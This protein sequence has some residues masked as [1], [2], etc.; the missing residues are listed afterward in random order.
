MKICIIS[1]GLLT[2]SPFGYKGVERI[3][4]QMANWLG[5]RHYDVTLVA[6]KGSLEGNF[7]LI[8]TVPEGYNVPGLIDK[9][10]LHIQEAVKKLQNEKF[11]LLINHQ[12]RFF[13]ENLWI[14]SD[15]YHWHVHGWL[16]N[17][18]PTTKLKI[19]AR[20]KAH[21]ELLKQ[22]FKIWEIDYCYNFIE[23]NNYPLVR[24]K[25][26]Y[27]LFFSRICRE[28]GAHNFLEIA[29]KFPDYKFVIAG[30]DDLEKG[31]DANYL[32]YILKL[33]NK[34]KNVEY[35]GTVTEK[36]KIELISKAKAVCVPWD[37]PYFEVF[38]LMIIESLACGTPFFGLKGFGGPDEIITP[39]CGYL[40][41][42][43]TDLAGAIGRLINGS[44]EFKPEECRKRAEDFDINKIMAEYE[45]K[46]K[47]G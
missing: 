6:C 24:D 9:D 37:K 32:V 18:P 43:L 12:G 23:I 13:I 27:I 42:N 36:E 11:D 29:K 41:N 1:S 45:E 28:K 26:D 17:Y 30:M 40:A 39:E 14:G 33:C 31:T 21:M 5:K 8:E 3:A 19:F 35:L 34:L 46:I 20:S 7:K 22:K 10:R 4:W 15:N 47:N 25:G 38:G 16:P 2:A 44:L